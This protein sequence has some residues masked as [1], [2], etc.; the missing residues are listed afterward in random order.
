MTPEEQVESEDRGSIC[1]F[2]AGAVIFGIVVIGIAVS[3]FFRSGDGLTEEGRVGQSVIAQNDALQ[4]RAYADYVAGSCR[5]IVSPEQ[6]VIAAQ[7]K[8]EAARGNRYVDDVK[9]VKIT[10]DTATATVTYHYMKTEDTKL[11]ADVS[12]VKED[13]SWRVCSQYQ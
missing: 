1:P 6:N 10:G 3:T 12:F 4:R 9:D 13:G 11:T 7:D 5:A 8:S 2:I